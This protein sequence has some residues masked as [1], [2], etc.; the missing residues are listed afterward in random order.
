MPAP[1]CP[2]QA[3]PAF[4]PFARSRLL[5]PF[6]LPDPAYSRLP[7]PGCSRCSWAPLPVLACPFLL[8]PA[9]PPQSAPA[10]PCLFLP[11][12]LCPL[13]PG[14]AFPRRAAPAA[15]P[16]LGAPARSCQLLRSPAC[17]CVLPPVPDCSRLF[18]ATSR[19]SRLLLAP[20]SCFYIGL[21]SWASG[22]LGSSASEVVGFCGPRRRPNQADLNSWST[23]W[24]PGK[25]G[26]S[27]TAG[28]TGFRK[29]RG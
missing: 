8:T 27:E 6:L 25:Y 21:G 20:P 3:S 10:S 5:V 7:C 9:W 18:L 13:L 15:A 24:G 12:C 1:A 2:P 17:P 16:V 4:L 19:C 26:G 11:A 22:H 23:N 29:F 14:P 28:K